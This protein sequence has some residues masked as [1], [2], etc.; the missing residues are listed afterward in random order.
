MDRDISLDAIKLVACIF[1]CTLH[2]IG[3]F[4]SESPGFHLSYLYFICQGLQFHCFY[5]KRLLLAPKDGG[6][7]YYYRKIFNIV[8]IVCVFTFI[9]DI[10]KLA[11][12]DISILI[13]FKQACSSLFFRVECSLYFGFLEVS[14]LYML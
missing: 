8:K 6:I 3:M 2:T 13:P 5:G 1:V 7:K 14:S 9:F 4:M 12:G 11:R 10:P